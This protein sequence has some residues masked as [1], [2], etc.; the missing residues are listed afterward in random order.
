VHGEAL[1]DALDV[2]FKYRA[3]ASGVE[4][5]KRGTSGEWQRYGYSSDCI[6]F[7]NS[8]ISALCA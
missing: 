1:P 6:V 4:E 2:R 7:W 3:N 8:C 5:T